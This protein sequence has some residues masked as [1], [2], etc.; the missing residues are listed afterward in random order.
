MAGGFISYS[1]ID[2]R[3]ASYI[4]KVIEDKFLEELKG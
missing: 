1:S 4:R 3:D 2:N